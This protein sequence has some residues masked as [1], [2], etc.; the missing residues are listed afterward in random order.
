[1]AGKVFYPVKDVT[2]IGHL[3]GA[4]AILCGVSDVWAYKEH[5][6]IQTG[7]ALA[8]HFVLMNA[9]KELEVHGGITLSADEVSAVCGKSAEINSEMVLSVLCSTIA[10]KAVE[11]QSAIFVTANAD[12]YAKKI[13]DGMLSELM[14]GASFSACEIKHAEDLVAAMR[15]GSTMSA[16][17]KSVS[18]DALECAMIMYGMIMSASRK[19]VELGTET[20]VLSGSIRAA[21]RRLRTVGDID[22]LL[23]SDVTDWTMQ[24]FYYLEV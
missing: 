20:I 13:V 17:S 1:M 24:D 12:I 14:F 7:I 18:S 2:L 23:I 9:I 22:A 16:S 8:A 10:Q 19:R 15:L 4:H 21:V 11:I 6:S 3:A 5:V